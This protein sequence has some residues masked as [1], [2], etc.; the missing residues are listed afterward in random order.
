MD[1]E[2]HNGEP[3][4]QFPGPHFPSLPI[5]VPDAAPP[6]RPAHER[7]GSLY[8]LGIGGL[9][10][11]VAMVGWFAWEAWSMR[12]VW[13]A[14]YV[15]H[16]RHRPEAERVEAAYLLSRDPRVGQ[17]Q[18]WDIALR[19]P[20]PDLAR[21]LMAEALTAEAAS[22]DPNV[23]AL[24][25]ARSVGWPSWLRLLLA[26]PLAYAAAEGVAVPPGPLRE[27]RDLHGSE[28]P[29]IA[30]W[31]DFALAA[32]EP[33]DAAARAALTAEAEGHGRT[34]ALARKLADALQS[35][36]AD[37]VRRLDDA[38]LWLRHNNP[39]AAQVW[40]GWVVTGNRIERSRGDPRAADP[41]R[42]VAPKLH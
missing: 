1:T 32:T 2:P 8:T 12:G 40:S 5:V 15:L 20:L 3:G 24:S 25:V 35:Q 9:I 41:S 37:R 22:G 26:R 17:R 16:D 38:T 34:A 39:A 7:Y 13:S 29:A 30:L 28:E 11:L 4:V 42:K 10:V 21:Y 14:I 19:K 27:L 33:S 23:Y 6:R 31:A 36:G 18:F